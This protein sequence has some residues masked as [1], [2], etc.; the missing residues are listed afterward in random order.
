MATPH[1]PA[2]APTTIKRLASAVYQLMA[3]LAGMQLDLFT[4]LKDGLLTSEEIA[5]VI[6]VKAQLAPLLYELVVAELLTLQDGRFSN[7]PEADTFLVAGRPASLLG[8][9]ENFSDMGS[10]LLKAATS[11]RTNEILQLCNTRGARC[12]FPASF[13]GERRSHTV[14]QSR[15]NSNRSMLC[16]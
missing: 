8:R 12:G 13:S 15:N 9:H 6:G 1:A 5:V 14:W 2:N 16:P 7:A 3:M 4:Q 11:I 10:A